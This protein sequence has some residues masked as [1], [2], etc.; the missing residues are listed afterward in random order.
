MEE[1]VVGPEHVASQFARMKKMYGD[2]LPILEREDRLTSLHFELQDDVLCTVNIVLG[3]DRA[4]IQVFP[5]ALALV[6]CC[7]NGR[8]L[9][10]EQPE[11]L[12]QLEKIYEDMYWMGVKK[13]KATIFDFR[14]SLVFFFD[15][16]QARI[17]ALTHLAKLNATY[18]EVVERFWEN[19][20]PNYRQSEI[21]FPMKI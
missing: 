7:I 5:F 13:E 15:T 12:R 14:S 11:V 21:I 3:S 2:L 10:L 16:I 18:H 20:S 19:D 6:C 17:D 4:S 8:R 9:G 1:Q